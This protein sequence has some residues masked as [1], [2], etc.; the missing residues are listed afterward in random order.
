LSGP[1]RRILPAPRYLARPAC[2]FVAGGDLG[3]DVS[4]F[5]RPRCGRWGETGASGSLLRRFG[6]T[7]VLRHFHDACIA[8]QT[9][10][11]FPTVADRD[12]ASCPSRHPP[13]RPHAGRETRWL[14][15]RRC[16]GQVL[17]V[18]PWC[19]P[20]VRPDG[21]A[22]QPG[23]SPLRPAGFGSPTK[24][25]RAGQ[26]SPLARPRPPSDR[27]QAEPNLVS[28]SM[29]IERRSSVG[30]TPP[31]CTITQSFASPRVAP[32]ATRST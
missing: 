1:F 24:R 22:G 9:V 6:G 27:G 15:R 7:S 12:D 14:D 25:C 4:V 18:S 21:R 11:N 32:V 26:G 10:G 16:K 23:V 29:P 19:C 13:S 30:S 8:I 28:T 3:A 17:G 5:V 20:R 2:A 31:A